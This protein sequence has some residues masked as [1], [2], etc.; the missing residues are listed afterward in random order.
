[1]IP[2][3]DNNPS[4]RTPWVNYTLILLNVLVFVWEFRLGAALEPTIRQFGLVPT[5]FWR[6]TGMVRW[7]PVLTSMFLHG[8]TVHLVSNVLALWFFGGSVENRLGHLRYLLFYLLCG[9]EAALAHLYLNPTS[10][11]P[12]VG[13]NG[14]ISGVLAAYLI[15]FPRALVY[16]LIPLLIWVEV[17]GI[18]AVI[19]FGVWLFS[20]FFNDWF[21]L[22]ADTLQ[23]R[24]GVAWW[25]HVGGFGTGVVLV[26]FFRYMSQW[27]HAEVD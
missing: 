17:V 8:G 20:Q 22:S 5:H 23:A 14:A 6:E 15:M 24:G 3:F 27:R 12:S 1:M 4:R 13:A 2:L 16:T 18:P 21:A 9:V 25:A 11:I 7:L 26:W 10:S 19:Y